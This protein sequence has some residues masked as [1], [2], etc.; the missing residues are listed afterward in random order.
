MIYG[1][2][3]QAFTP[4]ETNVQQGESEHGYFALPKSWQESA[5]SPSLS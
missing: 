1:H 5:I 2:S 3:A 4:A